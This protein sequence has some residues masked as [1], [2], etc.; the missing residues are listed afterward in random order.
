M[1]TLKLYE[2]KIISDKEF[3]VQIFE[4]KIKKKGVYYPLHW[5]EHLE[6]HYILKGKGIMYCN[7]KKFNV[8]EDTLVIINSNELHKGISNSTNFHSLVMIFE[9]DV[10]SKEIA[11]HHVIFQTL[12][13][14]DKK[15]KS[16]FLSIFKENFEKRFGYKLAMKGKI[17]ELISYLIRNY[18]SKALSNKQNII[19]TKNLTR[20]NT[21]IQYIQENYTSNITVKDLAK[22]IHL[23][24]YRF[25]HLFKE[26]I[27]Q[28]PINYINE[29]RLKKAYNLLKQHD[30]SMLEICFAVGFNDYNNFGRLFKKYYGFPP[31]KV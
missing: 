12:I 25:S 29:I 2:K 13:N 22:L 18:V 17:Y 21:V 15:I 9:M 27:G 10:F 30:M 14:S 23:S 6:M 1:N 4:N 28:S 5:H 8:N 31:S 7:Q 26:N 3:P 11:N 24:E 19:R 20:L 16:L